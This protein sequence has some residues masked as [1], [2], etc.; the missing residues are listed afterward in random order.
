MAWARVC[1]S[2]A[3]RHECWPGNNSLTLCKERAVPAGHRTILWCHIYTSSFYW[4][5]GIRRNVQYIGRL[6]LVPALP[7]AAQR[8]RRLSR[9]LYKSYRTIL[10]PRPS[11]SIWSTRGFAMDVFNCFCSM[12]LVGKR[13]PH[14]SLD[15]FSG[16]ESNHGATP[17]TYLDLCGSTPHRPARFGA[18]S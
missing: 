11:V 13:M 8:L 7:C 10:I 3:R 14:L 9:I 4:S 6:A 5:N 2:A 12:T 16:P 15:S 17:G 1:A 18:R